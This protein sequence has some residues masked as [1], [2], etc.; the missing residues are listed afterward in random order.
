[1]S[2]KGD[3]VYNIEPLVFSYN[4][5]I[6]K[7]VAQEQAASGV[8]VRTVFS[9]SDAPTMITQ[10]RQAIVLHAKAIVIQP[11]DS[12]AAVVPI[13]AAV[14]AGICVVGVT[15]FTGSKP[16]RFPGTYAYVG[17]NSEHSGEIIGDNLAKA[18]GYRGDVAILLG[19]LAN[20]TSYWR[21]QGLKKAFGQY[22]GIHIVSFQQTKFDV[23]TARSDALA[24]VAKYGSSLKAMY[25]DTNPSATIVTEAINVPAGKEKVAIGSIGGEKAYDSLIARGLATVDIAEDPVTQ[26][27]TALKYAVDCIQHKPSPG[28]VT[29]DYLVTHDTAFGKKYGYVITKANARFFQA[30][31]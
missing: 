31:W 12:A 17:N 14:K 15:V 5:A 8:N 13:E 16:G 18:I 4:T 28:W 2:V 24:L 7:G 22:H 23:N 20:G 21:Y 6:D 27:A 19:L 9:N 30:Q 11:E 3:L 25:V 1:M 26:G 10:I 29:A